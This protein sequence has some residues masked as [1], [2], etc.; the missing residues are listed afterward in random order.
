VIYKSKK[1]KSGFSK[2]PKSWELPPGEKRRRVRSKTYP[3][4]ARAMAEQWGQPLKNT[5]AVDFNSSAASKDGGF[6]ER[7]G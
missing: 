1:T 6:L 2:Y 7:Y 3:G 4:I 5:A